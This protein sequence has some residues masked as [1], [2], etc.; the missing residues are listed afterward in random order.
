MVA[1]RSVVE[2]SVVLGDRRSWGTPVVSPS[3]AFMSRVVSLGWHPS[4]PSSPWAPRSV[5]VQ[6]RC[7]LCLVVLVG[8]RCFARLTVLLR[9]RTAGS[10]WLSA[11]QYCAV[12]MMDCR[13][14]VGGPA[15]SRSVRWLHRFPSLGGLSTSGSRCLSRWNA[16]SADC[17]TVVALRGFSVLEP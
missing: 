5:A 3:P 14:V 12:L 13:P 9:D 2:S 4:C 1:P 15:V 6:A 10:G 17:P 16:A 7:L 11:V 8:R